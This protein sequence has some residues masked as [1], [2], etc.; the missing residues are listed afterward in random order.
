M[1]Y[2]PFFRWESIWSYLSLKACLKYVRQGTTLENTH[3]HTQPMWI[4]MLNTIRPLVSVPEKKWQ[5]HHVFL[6]TSKTTLL[7]DIQKTFLDTMLVFKFQKL[8]SLIQRSTPWQK[9]KLFLPSH[10]SHLLHP[11][12]HPCTECTQSE[13]GKLPSP[14]QKEN[15]W[16]IQWL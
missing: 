4:Y 16:L 1:G 3:T 14:Q 15:R 2:F 9:V 10:R 11:F 7:Y 13:P 6:L 12:S 5:P 8:I